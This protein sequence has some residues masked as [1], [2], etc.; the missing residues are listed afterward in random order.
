MRPEESATNARSRRRS[1]AKSVPYAPTLTTLVD[2]AVAGDRV[3]WDMIVDR[4]NNMVWSVVRSFRFSDA[5]ANDAA[6]MIWL[7]VVENLHKVR[8][9]ERLGLWIATTSRRECMRLIEKKSRVTPT[10]PDTGFTRLKAPG[11]VEMDQIS[12]A[13]AQR[14]LDSMQM[15]STDCQDLLRLVLCDPPLSYKEISEV[16]GIAVGTI[17]ARRQRCLLQLRAAAQL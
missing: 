15:L 17:G 14:V 6:Q 11:D 3:A 7:R 1:S 16:L 12:R 2:N 4:M 8:D 5:D 9:P 10:D 13:D